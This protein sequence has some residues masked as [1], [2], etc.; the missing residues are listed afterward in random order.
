MYSLLLVDDEL[1][2]LD[3]LYNNIDWEESGFSNVYRASSAE[4]ALEIMRKY[5]IDVVVT[6]ISM[7]GMDGIDMCR[8]IKESWPLCRVIFLS[9]YRDFDY[10]R[11]AVEMGVYQ[12]LVKPV[13]YEDIQDTVK[14]ALAELESAME[15]SD[16]LSKAREKME[17]M[18]EL[19][20]E[21]FLNGWLVQGL[22]DP[23]SDT[24]QARAAGLNLDRNA[25]GFAMLME[26]ESSGAVLHSGVWYLALQELAERYF[27]GYDQ[28]I[29]L[30]TSEKRLLLVMICADVQRAQ[31]LREQSANRLD[32]F[33]FSVDKSLGQSLS[34]YL[35][36]V[37]PPET[38][39]AAYLQLRSPAR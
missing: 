2:I 11:R 5:R 32:A 21:R 22:L 28:M 25:F 9:G 36:E 29:C 7:P 13:R 38:M 1:L 34:I 3:G 26:L 8:H 37:E 10:A 12:Y 19:L 17:S 16:L 24:E 4:A 35:S 39:H 6:D 20:K 33:Q 31:T 23:V 14:G 18:G 30:P 15:Q 27:S